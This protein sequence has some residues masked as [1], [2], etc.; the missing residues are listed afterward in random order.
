MTKTLASTSVYAYTT[1]ISVIICVPL[2]L[3]FEG[4]AL[5]EGSKVCVCVYAH[6]CSYTFVHVHGCVHRRMQ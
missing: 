1:L 5:V 2:A 6:A 3:I 4:G